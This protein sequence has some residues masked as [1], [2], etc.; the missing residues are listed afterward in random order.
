VVA[1]TRVILVNGA[2]QAGEEHTDP[3]GHRRHSRTIV[4][5]LDDPATLRAAQDETTVFV[6]HDGL[7]ARP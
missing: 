3:P 6:E 2:R 1:D 5:L 7:K 4:R